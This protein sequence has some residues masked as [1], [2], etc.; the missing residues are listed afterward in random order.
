MATVIRLRGVNFNNPNL[1]VVATLVR[2]GLVA[3]WRPAGGPTNLIDLSGNGRTLAQVGAPEFTAQ[4]VRGGE[5]GGYWA[6]VPETPSMTRWCAFRAHPEPMTNFTSWSFVLGGYVAGVSGSQIW[7]GRSHSATGTGVNAPR[8]NIFTTGES[9]PLESALPPY[10]SIAHTG[11]SPT[12]WFVFGMSI[13]AMAETVTTFSPGVEGGF[14]V[15]SPPAGRS[16]AARPLA[17]TLRLLSPSP[18]GRAEHP[19]ELAEALAWDVA[20]TQEEM[21][22]QYDLTR[23]FMADTRGIII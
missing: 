15:W 13:D 7:L 21:L 18:G 5:A 8:L 2:R 4:G 11:S 12:P 3:G 6:N 17:P 23:Q 19:V 10:G 22:R 16:I 1:P 20:L 14:R 9:P